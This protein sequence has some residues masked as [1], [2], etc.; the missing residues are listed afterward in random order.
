[1]RED[2]LERERVRQSG[3]SVGV[4]DFLLKPL[5]SNP[6]TEMPVE[7]VDLLLIFFALLY[8]VCYR[9]HDIR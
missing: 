1:V 2:F 3:Y 8:C 4:H 7:F 9:R 6:A 5:P